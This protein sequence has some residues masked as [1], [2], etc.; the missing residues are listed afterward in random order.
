MHQLYIRL[1]LLIPLHV[2]KLKC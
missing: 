1:V 2:N